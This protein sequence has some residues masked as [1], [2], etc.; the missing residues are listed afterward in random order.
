MCGVPTPPQ[1]ACLVLLREIEDHSVK[2]T[3]NFCA[4]CQARACKER[5]QPSMLGMYKFH[6]WV[7]RQNEDFEPSV[8]ALTGKQ[9]LRYAYGLGLRLL[10]GD[11][12]R[13]ES[14]GSIEPDLGAKLAIAITVSTRPEEFGRYREMMFRHALAD[15]MRVPPHCVRT[16]ERGWLEIDGVAGTRLALEV[17]ESQ[18]MRLLE[19]YFSDASDLENHLAL[20]PVLKFE[21]IDKETLSELEPSYALGD[22][23]ADLLYIGAARLIYSKG[24]DAVSLSSIGSAVRLSKID[25]FFYFKRKAALL[26]A[27]MVY[28][29]DLL[30]EKVVGRVAGE[31]D[32]ERRLA[33]LVSNHIRLAVRDPSAL[34]ILFTD[35][36]SC[37]RLMDHEQR[38]KIAERRAGYASMFHHCIE[39]IATRRKSTRP[40]DPEL[41]TS[42][43]LGFVLELLRCY[44]SEIRL[45]HLRLGSDE[46]VEQ[47]TRLALG[48]IVLSSD[49]SR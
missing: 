13:F 39:E 11:E 15:C 40:I 48:S 3:V 43:L 44:R 26:F 33:V 22:I 24:V 1:R 21:V 46:L 7:C 32:A 16:L 20:F 10:Q 45:C 23:D 49:A 31:Q 5:W 2:N 30:E 4:N 27:I 19:A 9:L 25:L 28:A 36:D 18:G 38:D 6:P 17:P 29:A 37:H 47:L 42:F 8:P 12:C 35:D 34:A 14:S 41:A